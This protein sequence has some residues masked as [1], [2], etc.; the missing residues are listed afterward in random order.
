LR[1][2]VKSGEVPPVLPGAFK[3]KPCM[4]KAARIASGEG[5]PALAVWGVV[6]TTDVVGTD[7]IAAG[8]PAGVSVVGA[9]VAVRAGVVDVTGPSKGIG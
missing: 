8:G 4:A 9:V 7:S 1:A 2:A 6:A 5:L 3:V